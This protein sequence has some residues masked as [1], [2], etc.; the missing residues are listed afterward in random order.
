MHFHSASLS[1]L[2]NDHL[3]YELWE[4]FERGKQVEFTQTISYQSGIIIITL[5]PCVTIQYWVLIAVNQC[6]EKCGLR[7]GMQALIGKV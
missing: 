6:C 3:K 7:R 4:C 1:A 2:R 5:E